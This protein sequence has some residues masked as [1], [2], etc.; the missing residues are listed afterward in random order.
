MPGEPQ[1]DKGWPGTKNKRDHRVWPSNLIVDATMASVRAQGKRRLFRSEGLFFP[2]CD[3]NAD[4]RKICKRLGVK[5]K[6]TPHDLRRT[7][8]TMVTRLGFGR[9]AMDRILNHKKT[10]GVTDVYDRYSYEEEDKRIMLAVAEKIWELA[11][12]AFHQSDE[13]QGDSPWYS[14]P[15]NPLRNP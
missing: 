3:M 1:P 12:E 14:K 7:F 15:L 6:V 9:E 11:G 8:G 10:K 5:E 13:R 2:K 4:M